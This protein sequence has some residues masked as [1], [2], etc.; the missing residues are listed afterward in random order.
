MPHERLHLQ[1]RHRQRATRRESNSVQ[2][3]RPAERGV[4]EAQNGPITE[5]E[6]D[7]GR[8][9]V[10]GLL[11]LIS[12]DEPEG[13]DSPLGVTVALFRMGL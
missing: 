5:T 4:D 12:C 6:T 10:R 8:S 1:E 7:F 2:P 9:P 3:D 11:D 13:T